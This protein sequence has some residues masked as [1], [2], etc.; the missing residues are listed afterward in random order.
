MAWKYQ[1]DNLIYLDRSFVTE[2]SWSIVIPLNI[3]KDIL[4]GKLNDVTH[5]MDSLHTAKIVINSRES[6][7]VL[8]LDWSFSKDM[9]H[10]Y[11]HLATNTLVPKFSYNTNQYCT[12]P[13]KNLEEQFLMWE[14]SLGAEYTNLFPYK[15]L[16]FLKPEESEMDHFKVKQKFMDNITIYEKEGV[17]YANISHWGGNI[18]PWEFMGSLDYKGLFHG[19]C[20]FVLP[21]DYHNST[22]THNFLDWSIKLFSGT[23]DHGKLN[24]VGLIVTWDGAN[25]F[26]TFKDGELHGPAFAFGRIPVFDIA[27]RI[28]FPKEVIICPFLISE[29]F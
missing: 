6:D 25:I 8:Q 18:I 17:F 24:G 4:V 1:K 19:T 27:V 26:A 28:S 21:V 29:G 9:T 22:G 15:A 20:T 11:L 16:T 7:C 2:N 13:A 23:F 14:N 3:S 12:L 5:T 10:H